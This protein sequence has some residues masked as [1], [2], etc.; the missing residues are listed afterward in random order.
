MFKKNERY[1]KD[2]YRPV[3]LLPSQSKICKKIL[4]VRLCEYLIDTVFFHPFQSGFR[5]NHST[6]SQLTYIIHRIYQCLEE[7]KEVRVVFLDI[8]KAFDRVWHEGLICKLTYLGIDG[9]L[10]AWL[11]SYLSGRRQRVTLG[12]KYS[13]WKGI[14]AGVP[15]GS[16]LGPLL[17]LIYI[18]NMV[19]DVQSEAFL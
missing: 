18:N 6:T 11:Q 3:S 2:N 17:F 13:E 15:Q 4:F 16:V 9:P 7:G 19:D 10:L 8:S 12:G 1:F 14:T 5:P